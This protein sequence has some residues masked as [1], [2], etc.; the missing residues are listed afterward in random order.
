MAEEGNLRLLSEEEKRKLAD[1]SKVVSDF[2][3]KKLEKEAQKNWDLFYKRNATNFFKDRHWTTA[4]F[5]ELL[6]SNSSE[7]FPIHTGADPGFFLGG[8]APLRNDFNL[9][10]CCCC[11]FFFFCGRIPLIS[12]SHRS[13]NGE[14]GAHP[15]PRSFPVTHGYLQF[16]SVDMVIKCFYHRYNQHPKALQVTYSIA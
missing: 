16:L 4:E 5:K 10:P 6:F 8:D 11:C 15:C 14:G 13:S 7:V 9:V 1:N 2:K 3:Q 12:E